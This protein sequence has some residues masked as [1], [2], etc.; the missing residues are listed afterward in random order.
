M[1]KVEQHLDSIGKPS[2]AAKVVSQ[3][4][5]SIHFGDKGATILFATWEGNVPLRL[6]VGAAI[7]QQG[8]EVHEGTA[9]PTE[10]ER[11]VQKHLDKI[12]ATLS[13]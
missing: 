4:R 6:A 10:N 8:G 5:V 1:K 9:P 12:K 7:L 3:C 11:R 13:K 2:D